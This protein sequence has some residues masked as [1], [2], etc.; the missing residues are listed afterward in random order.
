[1]STYVE[2][3]NLRT[4]VYWYTYIRNVSTAIHACTYVHIE[5][6]YIR[7]YIRTDVH[8][9]LHQLNVYK[10]VRPSDIVTYVHTYTRTYLHLHIRNI[11]Y[12]HG[13]CIPEYVQYIFTH[14]QA[15][16]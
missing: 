15:K 16:T 3:T 12:I 2:G 8:S 1:M 13:C 5:Y 7:T 6:T 14:V 9:W 4:Y 11:T 10:K